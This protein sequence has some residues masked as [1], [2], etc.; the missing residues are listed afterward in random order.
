MCIFPFKEFFYFLNDSIPQGR[1]RRQYNFSTLAVF[2]QLCLSI[3]LSILAMKILAKAT[4][5]LV[6]MAVP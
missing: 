6:H 1:T 4:A 3:S 2:W 5:I